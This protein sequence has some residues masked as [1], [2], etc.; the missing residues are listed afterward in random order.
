VLVGVGGAVATAL[1][2]WRQADFARHE[3]ADRRAL[4]FPP[5]VR[6]ATITGSPELVARAAAAAGVVATDV[7][8]PVPVAEGGV[9][10][11]VRFDYARGSEIAA[12]LRAEVVKAAASRRKRPGGATS[13]SPVIRQSLR[14]HLDDV[15]PFEAR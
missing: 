1:T 11:I 2:T 13:A 7:L 3:L 4:R 9:R 6:V 8:G 14:L 10:T 12:V 5:A 15:E